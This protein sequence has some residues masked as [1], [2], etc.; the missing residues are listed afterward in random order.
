MILTGSTS[1]FT[2]GRGGI[3]YVV[4]KFAVRGCVLSLAHELAPEIRVNG[5]APGGTH[6]T[7]LRGLHSLGLYDRSLG[8]EPARPALGRRS[9]VVV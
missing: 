2:P 5:V 6:S 7:D 4:S 3:L 9:N 8:Q 1:S